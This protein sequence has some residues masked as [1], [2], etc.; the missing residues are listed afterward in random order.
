MSK[1]KQLIFLIGL[2]SVQFLYG[3]TEPAVMDY[4]KPQDYTI[5]AITVTGVNYLD[6]NVVIGLSGLAV[7]DKIT[8]PGDAITQAIKK[9]WSQG[10]FSE[11]KIFASKIEG[12]KISLQIKLEERPRL[13][14]VSFVGLKKSEIDDLN[15]KLKLRAGIQVTDEVLK[16][17]TIEIKK[18]F[19]EKGFYNLQTRIQ[20]TPDTVQGNRVNLRIL[21]EKNQKVR[22]TDVIFTGNKEFPEKRLRRTFKKTRKISLNFFKNH[23]FI[24][25]NY[26]DDKKL[27]I[28]FYNDNGFRDAKIVSDSV[29]MVGMNRVIVNI[30]MYEGERYYYRNISWVGNTKYTGAQ[31]NQSLGIKKGDIYNQ[32]LLK[33]RLE[34]D[35]DAVNSLYLD[36]GYLFFTL[37]P[38]EVSIQNDSIDFEMRMYEGKQATINNVIIKGNTKTNEHVVRREI[39]TLPG[40]LFSKDKII[41]TVRELATLGH[42]DP[43]K[44]SPEP[45][46]NIG[47]GTVDIE[48]GLEEK[49]NDQLE[50]SGGW[51]AGMLIG[52]LGIRF[53]NFS[54]RHIFEPK[55]WRPVPSGDGQTL[56]LR[57]QSNGSYYRSYNI[58]FMEPWLGGTKP[59]S[60]TITAYNSKITDVS[61]NPLTQTYQNVS[62][63]GWQVIN[64]VS[65]GLGR[66]LSWPDDYFQLYNEISYQQYNMHNF[67]RYYVVMNNGVS[68]NFNFTTTLSRN[69]ISQPIYPRNGSNFSLSLNLTPPYSYIFT[70]G[71][72]YTDLSMQQKYR[73][74]EYFKWTFKSENYLNLVDK[75]VMFTRA[76]YGLKGFY[77]KTIGQSPFEGYYVGGDGMVGYNY[78]GYEIIP[79]RGYSNTGI[80]NAIGALTPASGANLYAK[81]TLEF[82]YPVSL[83]PTATIYGLAFLE[84]GNAWTALYQFN[85]FQVRRSAGVGVRAFLPMFGMLGVDWGYGFDDIPGNPGQNHSQ[86]AFTLGQQF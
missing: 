4:T 26:K 49:A 64:G 66:R 32:K 29:V 74:I 78:Y 17:I 13:A 53:S 33:K 86:F 30:K 73:W 40:E 36:Y 67:N 58:S 62:D 57:A 15:D 85:P 11:V 48:Y 19:L 59:N 41:R 7:G 84:G 45:H 43:E 47:D 14:K 10:L 23:K 39:R 37:I 46:P 35:E 21:V 38:A 28:D 16:K 68:N 81:Y 80:G 18:H 31:L 20:Q 44:I 82:R 51:G 55:E 52:T 65:V 9:F 54:A 25:A 2:I 8:V 83:N 5:D 61:Y 12:D 3:Q 63:G 77:N 71:K 75:L 34:S 6:P 72:N 1:K 70:P 79:L 76:Q 24:L 50:V 27:L 56:S 22:I 69:S 60:M 42:F